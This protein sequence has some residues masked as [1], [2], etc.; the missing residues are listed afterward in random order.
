[1]PEARKAASVMM[2]LRN[3]TELDFSAVNMAA[4]WAHWSRDW[5]FYVA[6]RELSSKPVP[7]RW[8]RFFFNYAGLGA[9]E[10]ASHFEWAKADGLSALL[11]LFEAYCNPRRNVVLERYNFHAR[12]QQLGENYGFSRRTPLVGQDMRIP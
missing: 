10:V 4:E 7:T 6:A 9:Q 3:T 12:M 1:M 11:E 5:R 8:E 2:S